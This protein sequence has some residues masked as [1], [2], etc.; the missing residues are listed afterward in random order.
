[1]GYL[2]GVQALLLVLNS[3]MNATSVLILFIAFSYVFFGGS[4]LVSPKMKLE[5]ARYNL[6]DKRVLI[7]YLQLTGSLGLFVGYFA[8]P[9]LAMIASAGLALLMFLGVGVR[10]KIKD[11][12]VALL[13][14]STYGLLCSY[15]FFSLW[16]DL[17]V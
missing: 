10:L 2:C 5:F 12:I 4:C 9:M 11:P 1:M 15:V 3:K 8:Y 13:P 7:G 16:K 14:A 17:M 6:K